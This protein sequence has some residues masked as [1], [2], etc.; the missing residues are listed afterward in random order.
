MTNQHPPNT[1]MIVLPTPWNDDFSD[2]VASTYLEI[3]DR[4]L[5]SEGDDT[6]GM[7][8]ESDQSAVW[9]RDP[10][11]DHL[12]ESIAHSHP[13]FA[14]SEQLIAAQ[15]KVSWRVNIESPTYADARFLVRLMAAITANQSVATL[16]PSTG[17]AFPPTFTRQLS[18]SDEI[19]S[20]ISFFVHAWTE[21]TIMRT[22]GLTAFGFPEVETEI[23]GGKNEAY[24]NLLDLSASIILDGMPSLSRV[25]DLGNAQHELG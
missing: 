4:E 2:R 10:M 25:I 9:I 16:I 21:G 3:W 23:T 8:R 14:E 12:A 13:P 5:H 15:H 19:E 22:R 17:R 7:F 11:V 24:F 1:L 6:K 18:A 20:V